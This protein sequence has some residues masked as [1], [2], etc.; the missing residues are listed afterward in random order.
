MIRSYIGEKPVH[1]HENVGLEDFLERLDTHWGRSAEVITVIAH[2]FWNGAEIDAVVILPRAIAVID[3]KSH[4]GRVQISENG[5]WRGESGL[6]KG[7][8]KLNPFA[9]VRDNKWAVKSW[10]DSKDLLASCNLGHISGVVLFSRAVTVEGDLGGKIGSWFYVTDLDRCVELL[11]SLASPQIQVSA[12]QVDAIVA[13]LGVQ[14]YRPRRSRSRVVPVDGPPDIIAPSVVLTERQREVLDAIVRFLEAPERK[15]LSVLGMTHTGKTTLLSE[16]LRELG[17]TGRQAIVLTPNTRIARR[18]TSQ[19]VLACTSI[20]THMYDRGSAKAEQPADHGEK[21]KSKSKVFPFRACLDPEDCV[22]LID[23]AHLIGNEFFELDDGSRYGSGRLADDFILFTNLQSLARQVVFFGD[24][25]QL[26]RGRRDSMPLFGDFQRTYGLAAT[27][28]SL[29]EMFEDA[30]RA[31]PLTNARRLAEAILSGQYADLEFESGEGFA[32]LPRAEAADRAKESFRGQLTE[33]WYIADTHAKTAKF[34]HWIR[35]Q[36]FDDVAASPM[37]VGDL[38]EVYGGAADEVADPFGTASPTLSSGDRVLVESASEPGVRQSQRLKGRVPEEIAFSTRRVDVRHAGV[39]HSVT[40]LEEFLLADKP[41]LDPDVAVAINVWQER[42]SEQTV[43]RLRYGY[44]TTAHH[45][46]GMSQ[47]VCLVDAGSEGGRHAESYFRW[48][49]TATT[50]AS[51]WCFVHNFRALDPFDEAQWGDR[52]AQLVTSL[53]IGIGLRFS[54][55]P[56]VAP[57]NSS[58]SNASS[59][60]QTWVES[61]SLEHK[62]RRLVEPLGWYVSARQ[63]H[64]YQDQFQLR[65]PDGAE[66]K[67]SISYNQGQE[68]TGMRVSDPSVGHELL[69][70]IAESAAV[71]AVEDGIGQKIVHYLQIRV[72]LKQ[73]RVVGAR[74]DGEYRLSAVLASAADGRALIEINHSKDGVV[75]AVRLIKFMGSGMPGLARDALV[76]SDE[77]A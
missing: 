66:L 1:T 75:S 31:I 48:L 7:G 46:Q 9:Q 13:A 29:S 65:G 10:L 63:T 51:R 57:G 34:N 42:H 4:G 28:V 14:E 2:A 43:A 41:E 52:G 64:S 71:N 19:G 27:E 25:C 45:A 67:L 38:L 44:A 22:Y 70:T 37:V 39:Q 11:G 30:S 56:P 49:Y 40:V 16:A 32:V 55:E 62:V 8:S 58:A 23:E 73:L 12:E 20:Y 24:P 60:N 5:P 35:R 15:S 76:T 21:Q 50:R 74:R 61:A 54:A 33:S 72:A 53:P 17:R 47:P 18:L 69:L 77:A 26:P 6:I 59:D 3:F 68:V 36:L